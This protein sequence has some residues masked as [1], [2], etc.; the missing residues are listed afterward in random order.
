MNLDWVGGLAFT[1]FFIVSVGKMA[2]LLNS[3]AKGDA[4]LYVLAGYFFI[5]AGQIGLLYL[6]VQ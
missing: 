1:L 5:L 3:D 6:A 2:M 4:R